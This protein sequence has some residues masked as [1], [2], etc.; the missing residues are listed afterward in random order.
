MLDKQRLRTFVLGGVAGALAGIL[1][2]P[3]SGKEFRGSIANRADEARERGRET[4]FEAQERMQERIAEARDRRP[5]ERK[6]RLAQGAA[7]QLPKLGSEVPE[8]TTHEAGPPTGGPNPPLL[9][10]VS[11]DESP[12]A[13]RPA[14]GEDPEEVRRRVQETRSRLQAQLRAQLDTREPENAPPFGYG[15]G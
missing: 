3:K 15:D 1:L 9:R 8:A 11:G 4:Y 2:A 13:L 5:A 6:T 7:E 12:E 14:S 10:G